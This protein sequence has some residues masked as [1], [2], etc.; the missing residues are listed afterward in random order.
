MIKRLELDEGPF[1]CYHPAELDYLVLYTKNN[2][3]LPNLQSLSFNCE[4]L[5]KHPSWLNVLLSPSLSHIA[6]PLISSETYLRAHDLTEF[7]ASVALQ[8]PA[9]KELELLAHNATPPLALEPYRQLSSFWNLRSLDTNMQ[10]FYPFALA[11]IG[12]LPNLEI[13]KVH[14]ESH[15]T[16]VE[17]APTLPDDAFPAL[18][19]LWICNF[20]V[21][22]FKVIWSIQQLVARLVVANV[23]LYHSGLEDGAG[24]PLKDICQCSPQ[25]TSLT[26]EYD[27]AGQDLSHDSFWPLKQLPLEKLTIPWLNVPIAT[28]KTLSIACPLLRELRLPHLRVTI[29]DLQ[30]FAQLPRLEILSVSVDWK[31]CLELDQSVP[32]STFTSPSLWQLEGHGDSG[33]FVEPKL[34]TKTVV[35]VLLSFNTCFFDLQLS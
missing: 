6:I 27:G 30:Y 31:S 26:F 33:G 7:F 16:L 35:Y 24:D 18:R 22:E 4:V 32:R 15:T 28:C 1:H 12:S 17:Q 21:D 5:T 8:C 11:A 13:L 20:V 23:T 34:I 14:D 9:L 3:L 25:I 19:E 2:T 10:I 29:S